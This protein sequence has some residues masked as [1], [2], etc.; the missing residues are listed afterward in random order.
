[1]FDQKF[2]LNIILHPCKILAERLEWSGKPLQVGTVLE[3]KGCGEYE[4]VKAGNLRDDPWREQYVVVKP[5]GQFWDKL[6]KKMEYK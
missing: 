1:M 6:Q 5:V 3:L 4:V 2:W